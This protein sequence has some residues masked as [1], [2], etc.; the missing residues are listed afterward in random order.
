MNIRWKQNKRARIAKVSKIYNLLNLYVHIGKWWEEVA[1]LRSKNTT[2]GGKR[3]LVYWEPKYS[4]CRIIS[5]SPTRIII[6][7]KS[8]W[9]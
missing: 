6:W 3:Q 2:I 7:S 9:I 1:V 8:R 5:G 4:I